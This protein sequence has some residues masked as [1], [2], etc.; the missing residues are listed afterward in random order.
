ME[1]NKPATATTTFV[2]ATEM[3]SLAMHALLAGAVTALVAG[4]L[5]VALTVIAK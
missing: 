4:S 5:V 1:L 3:L 2:I